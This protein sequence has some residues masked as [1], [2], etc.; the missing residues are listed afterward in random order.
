M[1]GRMDLA[2]DGVNPPKL[3]E[4]NGDTPSVLVES[5]AAQM[6]W[7]TDMRKKGLLTN[8]KEDYEG[9]K[10]IKIPK[11]TDQSNFIDKA[12]LAGFKNVVDQRKSTFKP[13]TES[14][15]SQYFDIGIFML[16][17]DK[18]S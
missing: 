16:E 14:F 7:M 10:R 8:L 11:D 4:Y 9:I 15:A 2:W 18:E 12:L 3:L 13:P 5:A 6:T 17:G 1:L